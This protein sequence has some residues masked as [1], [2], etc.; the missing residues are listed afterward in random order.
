M[1]ASDKGTSNPRHYVGMTVASILSERQTD[2]GFRES[3]GQSKVQQ[4]LDNL[5]AELGL[6]GR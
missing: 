2:A 5:L 6:V 4:P 3:N 1:L